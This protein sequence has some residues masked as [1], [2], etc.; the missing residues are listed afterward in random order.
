[1]TIRYTGGHMTL[2]YKRR[3]DRID[4]ME[5]F[6]LRGPKIWRAYSPDIADLSL[7]GPASLYR[8]YTK[9]CHSVL[10]AI[11][12]THFSDAGDRASWLETYHP[13]LAAPPND[14]F[15]LDVIEYLEGIQK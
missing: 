5:A 7:L 10:M 3:Q 8:I 15:V 14:L 9:W 2:T 6:L 12:T 4:R 1:M 13:D 11:L